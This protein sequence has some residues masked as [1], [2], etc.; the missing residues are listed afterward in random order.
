LA[1]V[2]GPLHSSEARG[3]VGSLTYNTWRG[4]SIVKA[5]TGPLKQYEAAQVD[6]RTKAAAATASWQSLTDAQRAPWYDYANAHTDIDWTGNPAR[7]T[8]YNWYIRINVRRQLLGIAIRTSPPDVAPDARMLT[9]TATGEPTR[10][11]IQWTMTPWA[12]L[13][14]LFVEIYGAGPYSAA[15]H[16]TIKQAKRLHHAPSFIT[17]WYWSGLTPG[18]YTVFARPIHVHGITCGWHRTTTAVT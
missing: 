16:P 4:I 9:L 11:H 7:L 14:D 2:V 17:S 3:S 1:K 8:A 18:H 5:R 10:A 12:P 15:R 13:A 6:V